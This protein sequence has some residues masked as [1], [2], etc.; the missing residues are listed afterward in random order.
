MVLENKRSFA[1]EDLKP[2]DVALISIIAPEVDD[3]LLKA[4]LA[5]LA[6]LLASPRDFSLGLMAIDAYRNIPLDPVNWSKTGRD[7]FDRAIFLARILGRGAGDRLEE[8]ESAA[9]DAFRAAC[10]SDPSFA[11]ELAKSLGLSRLGRR[12]A[13]TLGSALVSLA[14]AFRGTES[15]NSAR[16]CL[17]EAAMWF[18]AAGNSAEEAATTVQVADSYAE[19]AELLLSAEKPHHLTVGHLIEKAIQRYRSVP[20]AYREAHS[21]D[22][23]VLRLR[24]LLPD[25]GEKRVDDLRTVASPP[26]DLQRLIH[27]AREQLRAKIGEH[28][29]WS[30]SI[31]HGGARIAAIRDSA[32]EIVSRHPFQGLFDSVLLS[33][34]GRVIAKQSGSVGPR[35]NAEPNATAVW[36]QTIKLYLTQVGIVVQGQI[37]PALEEASIVNRFSEDDIVSIAALAPI[38]PYG[39]ERLIGKSLHLG[40]ERDFISAVHL[41]VPQIEH[42]VR[43]HLKANGEKTTTIDDSGIENELGL[44]TLVESSA[45]ERIFGEDLSFEI[46]ALFCDPLGPNLRNEIAHGLLDDTAFHAQSLVYAWHLGL[47]LVLVSYWSSHHREGT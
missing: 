24:K 25:V 13:A 32:T 7:A 6:W 26:I 18:R 21:V 19:E 23:K 41:L 30:L 47:R 10:N 44:S 12:S 45:L 5:D 42:L 36:A 20:R 29:L 43:V 16:D 1:V 17:K 34:D 37:L 39:R 8:I 9:L 11:F 14:G 15:L 35:D 46:R 22:N 31:V 40:L 27:D 38:V 28:A 33:R 3:P 2:S 4:R